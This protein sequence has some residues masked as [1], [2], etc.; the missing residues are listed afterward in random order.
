[1]SHSFTGPSLF[2]KL[3]QLA[4]LYPPSLHYIVTKTL[5][6]IYA[7]SVSGWTD[8]SILGNN[9][10]MAKSRYC[11]RRGA[12]RILCNPF[13]DTAG[14]I[15]VNARPGQREAMPVRH[16]FQDIGCIICVTRPYLSLVPWVKILN[17]LLSDGT[18]GLA[19]M[20]LM[21]E[22]HET[23]VSQN[24][25]AISPYEHAKKTQF[26]YTET[27]KPPISGIDPR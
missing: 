26:L 25:I 12:P 22:W 21:V 15:Q 10:V 24:K 6:V 27:R 19:R 23:A 11:Q 9:Q 16:Q 7:D 5:K 17:N 8:K 3:L 1:M 14:S 18:T 2:Y 20:L 13:Q 4:P